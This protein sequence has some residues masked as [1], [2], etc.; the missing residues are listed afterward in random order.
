MRQKILTTARLPTRK[1]ARLSC[2]VNLRLYSWNLGFS[3][4]DRDH[5]SRS[6]DWLYLYCETWRK[7][8]E[9]GARVRGWRFRITVRAP[10]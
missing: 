6:I 9:Q 8:P 7:C 5:H 3:F 10:F 4:L 2:G 1:L